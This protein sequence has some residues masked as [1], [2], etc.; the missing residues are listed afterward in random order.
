MSDLSYP[1]LVGISVKNS[2]YITC[3]SRLIEVF[4]DYVKADEKKVG[5]TVEDAARYGS[6][7]KFITEVLLRMGSDKILLPLLAHDPR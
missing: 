6:L 1:I 5:Q 2:I 7:A 4:K 3:N